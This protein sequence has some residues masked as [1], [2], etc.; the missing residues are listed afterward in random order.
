MKSSYYIFGAHPRGY[1]MYQ[2]LRTL[3]PD[4]K[5][6]GFLFDNE[7]INPEEI[8]GVK[9]YDLKVI[10]S[11]ELDTDA[12]VFRA[13]RGVFHEHIKEVLKNFG[14]SEENIIPV[15]PAFDMDLRNK[16]VQRVFENEGR[17]FEKLLP[18]ESV[19]S[20]PVTDSDD[21]HPEC[22]IYVAKTVFDKDFSENVSLK[23][24]ESIIQVGTELTE[25]RLTDAVCFDNDGEN[26]STKNKQ[27]CELTALYWIWKHADQDII[28]LEHW[29]RRF[30]LPDNWIELFEKDE[31]DVILPV[32]LCVMPSLEE[33]Y[34]GRHVSEVWDRAMKI[35]E[36]LHPEDAE[37]AG[38][39][40]REHNL[41][42]P[43][44]M[45]IARKDILKEYCSWVFPVLL[46]LN[47]EIGALEDSYQNRYPG[48]LSER[49]L[50][51]YLDSRRDNFHIVYADKSFLS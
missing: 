39:Y 33:N 35:L 40:F 18:G 3:E 47:E 12:V 23:K 4:R 50:N 17:V 7:E 8:E 32:P 11:D 42:S 15:T 31:I 51:Y 14:F 27:F 25:S 46:R 48:F 13:T 49:L 43:C 1:T 26:I 37:A 29:R 24:Y 30:L 10:T 20:Y 16:Y 44:N 45:M 6:L 36:E 41:Y 38:R 5:I 28:G 34:R 19:E 2:Y 21:S 9:V 22:C